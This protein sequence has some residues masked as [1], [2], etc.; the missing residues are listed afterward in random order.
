M[1]FYYNGKENCNLVKKTLRAEGQIELHCTS[2]CTGEKKPT[3]TDPCFYEPT[4]D[5]WAREKAISH[6]AGI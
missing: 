3:V 2:V 1:W 5:Q 4:S 6:S